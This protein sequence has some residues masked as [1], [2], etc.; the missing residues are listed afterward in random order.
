V[1]VDVSLK[2]MQAE[3]QT[4]RS[5]RVRIVLAN[6]RAAFLCDLSEGPTAFRARESQSRI[7]MILEPGC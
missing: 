3:K 1:A 4:G 6:V 2:P 7:G 5:P